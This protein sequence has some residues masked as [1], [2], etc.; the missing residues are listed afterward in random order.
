MVE[1]LSKNWRWLAVRG[2]IAVLFGLLTLRHP[3]V[4]L[5]VL[6]LW[7]GAY[8]FV[9][10][11]SMIV[12][13]IS[14]GPSDTRRF[15]LFV[16]GSLAVATGLVTFFWPHITA[17][18]LLTLVAL[19]AIITGIAEVSAAIRLRKEIDGEWFLALAG[20]LA[21]ALGV[22]LLAQP[23]RGAKALVIWLGVYALFSG[24][25]L[26]GLSLRLR[27]WERGATGLTP[28]ASS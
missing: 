5:K 8:A 13:A 21:I 9:D 19:W 20:V 4:S 15:S 24:L 18:A 12:S 23:A 3:G 16:G 17:S 14:R 22:F 28:R 7:F 2:A 10:G 6:V 11:I 26:I 25:L 1:T 27:S